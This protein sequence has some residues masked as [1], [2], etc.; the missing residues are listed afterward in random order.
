MRSE[1]DVTEVKN[2]FCSFI[3]PE[4]SMHMG[5]HKHLQ[6]HFQG[7]WWPLWPLK[8]WGAMWSMKTC[9]HN[10]LK[11]WK[12]IFIYVISLMSKYSLDINVKHKWYK[13]KA[14]KQERPTGIQL[15]RHKI[16]VNLANKQ[17]RWY[18]LLICKTLHFVWVSLLT[19]LLNLPADRANARAI[20]LWE[21]P[22]ATT[23]GCP[24]HS[25]PQQ[26]SEKLL[27][28]LLTKVSLK[29]PRRKCSL[30]LLL[31]YIEHYVSSNP[32]IHLFSL[33]SFNVTLWRTGSTAFHCPWKESFNIPIQ[34]CTN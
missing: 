4:F 22:R 34:I 16:I 26:V 23:H 19:S 11:N 17:H 33:S 28:F 27:Q 7:I 15:E 1:R 10:L 2:I 12:D 29:F 3:A 9:V 18:Q 31:P 6:F 25:Q 32:I 30:M 8:A 24:T 13:R 14:C 21:R 5:A 20:N